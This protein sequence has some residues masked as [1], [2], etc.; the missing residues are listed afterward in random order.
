MNKVGDMR[1]WWCPQ[2]PMESFKFPVSSVEEGAK[3]MEALALYDIFQYEKNVK[4][5][6][7]N[8]GGLQV[9]EADAGYGEPDWCDWCDEETGEDD[10]I[11]FMRNKA[12]S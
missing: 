5:D 3:I 9:Y 11:Q 12:V 4:P 7:C 6:F 10:P 1:V 2:V 8:A